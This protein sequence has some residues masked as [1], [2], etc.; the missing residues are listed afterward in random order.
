MLTLCAQDDIVDT[1]A[2]FSSLEKYLDSS[3]WLAMHSLPTD[4]KQE[5]IN[6]LGKACPNLRSLGH[7]RNSQTVRWEVVLVRNLDTGEVGWS[8]RAV[9]EDLV[10]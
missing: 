6:R 7:W 5:T 10:A 2:R 8:E 9:P 1:L 3:L 4:M